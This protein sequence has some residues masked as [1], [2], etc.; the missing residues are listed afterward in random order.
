MPVLREHEVEIERAGELLVQL[1]A[2]PVERSAL[3]RAVVGADDR[4][5]APRCA[6]ADV[7][8]LQ[9]RDVLHAMVAR[10]VVRGRKPVGAAAADHDVVALLQLLARPPHAPDTED[11]L[12]SPAARSTTALRPRTTSRATMA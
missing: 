4:R 12:H 9:H 3:G 1:D 11:V 5:V 2:A 6:R 7:R 8:L 10:E